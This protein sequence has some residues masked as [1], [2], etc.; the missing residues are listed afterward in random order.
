[1]GVEIAGLLGSAC[2]EGLVALEVV[3]VHQDGLVS[4]GILQH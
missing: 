3:Q 4:H 2:W 1:M